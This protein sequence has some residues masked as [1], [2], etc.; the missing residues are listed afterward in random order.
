MTTWAERKRKSGLGK[1]ASRGGSRWSGF[2]ASY[3]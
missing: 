2:T 3:R 1:P